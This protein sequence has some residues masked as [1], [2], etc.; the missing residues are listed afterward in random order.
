MHAV[1]VAVELEEHVAAAEDEQVRVLGDDPVDETV[2]LQVGELRVGFVGRDD[3]LVRA[4]VSFLIMSRGIASCAGRT[5][6]PSR[7]R[8][9]QVV[10]SVDVASREVLESTP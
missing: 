3:V 4:K 7:R 9:C 1:A 10:T 8:A 2:A 6:M 5:W